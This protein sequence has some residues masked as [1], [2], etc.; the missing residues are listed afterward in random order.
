M[1]TYVALLR[2]INVGKHNRIAMADLRDIV[3]GIGYRDVR[4]LLNSGNVVFDA[5]DAPVTDI[6]P[7]ISDALREEQQLDV[8]VIVRT[9]EELQR[10]V[11]E[12]PFPEHAGDHTTLHVEFLTGPLPPDAIAAMKALP[13]GDDDWRLIGTHLYLA[14]PNKLTGARFLPVLPVPHT[15]RNWK[16]VLRLAEM[17]VADS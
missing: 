4:T 17:A 1:P 10:V 9:G 7:A 8:P 13:T 12:N 3:A 16:T 5:E 2:G 14:Y 15:S 6:A 11:V